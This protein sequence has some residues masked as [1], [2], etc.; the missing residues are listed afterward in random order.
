MGLLAP[1]KLRA[2]AGSL[3]TTSIRARHRGSQVPVLLWRSA[4]QRDVTSLAKTHA[5]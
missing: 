4:S 2:V 1:F 3:V 5:G